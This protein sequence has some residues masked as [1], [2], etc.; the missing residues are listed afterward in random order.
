[1]APNNQPKKSIQIQ[2][3]LYATLGKYLPSNADQYDCPS[4]TTAGDLT[5][6]LNLPAEQVK[7]VFINGRRQPLTTVLK[8]NDRVGIFPP[9]GGG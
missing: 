1:M 7:L 5:Y 6:L 8:K 4:G 9:V 2:V 3:K